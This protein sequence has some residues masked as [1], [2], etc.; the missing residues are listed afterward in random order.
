MML[1][2]DNMGISKRITA[3]IVYRSCLAPRSRRGGCRAAQPKIMTSLIHNVIPLP[4][5]KITVLT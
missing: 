3:G 5:L 2:D 4:S 1:A